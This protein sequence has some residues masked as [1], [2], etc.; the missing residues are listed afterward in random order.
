MEQ[1]QSIALWK[2]QVS[3]IERAKKQQHLALFF[4]VGTGKTRTTLEILRHHYNTNKKILRTLIIAPS[5]VCPN[6]VKEFSKFTKVNTN[7]IFLL[8]GSLK[9]RQS[10]YLHSPDD[11]IFITNYEAF[12]YQEFGRAMTLKPPSILILDESHRVK[13]HKAKRTRA[14]TALSDAMNKYEPCHRYILTGTP[15]LNDE[16]DLFSQFRVLDGGKLLGT[17]F[18]AYR[19]TYFFDR[20][21][22]MPKQ[23]HFYNWQAKSTTSNLLKEKIKVLA[24]DAKKSECLDLPPL[25]RQEVHVE[26]SPEQRKAYDSMKK[27]FIAF[28][29]SGVATASLA[30]T[31]VL[32]LQQILSGHIKQ[33]DGELFR[34]KENPR[35]SA[36]FDILSDIKEKVIIWSIF[37]ED[38]HV[39]KNICDGLG[40]KYAEVHGGISNKQK[41]IDS[42][43]NDPSVRVMIANQGAGG[44]G[45]NLT[46]ASVMIY[47]NRSFSLEHDIQSEARNYRGGSEIHEKITRIDLVAKGTVDEAVIKALRDKSDI[48]AKITDLRE[49]L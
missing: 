42:F 32:R 41:E 40:L 28:L 20:N 37:V 44:V 31:K 14:I 39:I 11:S 16:L 12:A 30:L 23:R 48:A 49:M 2:H 18:Y 33:E 5:A 43:Q 17:N 4:D 26:L 22:A 29:D 46:Q 25:I 13:D 10:I 35:A 8:N 47:Y 15:V 21:A 27:D 34:F 1:T 19:A 3:A 24:V 9:N 6:W 38:Y 45:I 7:K 36:L